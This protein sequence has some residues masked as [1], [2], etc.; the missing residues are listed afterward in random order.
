MAMTTRND[1]GTRSAQ[2][3][4]SAPVRKL[5][6]DVAA[7]IAAG[8][9]IDRPAAVVRELIDNSIDAGATRIDVDIAGGGIDRIRVADNGRGMTAEDLSICAQTHTTSKISAEDDLL[10]LS[11]LGFRGEALSSIDAVSRLEITTTRD[12][13]EAWKLCLGKVKPDRLSEGTIVLIEDLFANFPARRQF[14]KRASA[15]TLLCKQTV[16]EK[17]LAWP[18]IEFRLSVDG[19][20][21]LTLPAGDRLIDRALAALSPKESD[22]LFHEVEGAGQGVTFTAVL[23]S[24]DVVRADRKQLMVFANGRRI[25]DYSLLQA[26]EYGCEGHFPN[27]A[28]PFGLLFISIDP[29]LVDFNI[30][31]AKREARFR[32]PSAL[33]HAVSSVIRDFY[34]RYAIASMKR[35]F[36]PQE[37]RLFGDASN[38]S[39]HDEPLAVANTA[40]HDAPHVAP[41][42]TPKITTHDTQRVASHAAT[43]YTQDFNRQ[44]Q[45]P[46]DPSRFAREAADAGTKTL[47]FTY[48][49]QVFTTFLAVERGGRFY[50]VDQHAAHERILF[51]E[52]ISRSGEKQEL[53]VPYRIETS[54]KA[55]DAYLRSVQ[56]AVNASGFTLE[57]EGEG[58][59]QIVA[60]PVRWNGKRKDIADELL[61]STREP[62]EL[63]RELY[64]TSACRAACKAGD[65]LD[66]LTAQSLVERAFSLAEPV[67]PHG[68]PIWIVLDRD[69][70]FERIRRT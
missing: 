19:D 56:D 55:D 33:H 7:K 36:F 46:A 62:S 67:C 10:S 69:E 63:V 21:K 24:P 26:I 40:L 2:E 18:G 51:D 54:S 53:L 23:G 4:V 30:H 64:A 50:L 47:P 3:R 39:S 59:W 20:R 1:A 16:I 11:T 12:G 14:M 66:P 45:K 32:D 27:G 61:A 57:D 35:D 58:I 34:R 28:H 17:A 38:D 5:P 25:M 48:L 49:G 68:R 8:E 37:E 6:P 43:N 44:Y 13:R 31:P 60:V 9:V 52:Y 70:L 41:Y 42:A 29:S 15:E 65:T 22:S